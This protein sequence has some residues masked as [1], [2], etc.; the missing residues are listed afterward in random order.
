MRGRQDIPV[1]L[2]RMFSASGELLYI[3]QS[4]SPEKRLAQHRISADWITETALITVD[5]FSNRSSAMRAERSAIMAEAPLHNVA[6]NAKA[7]VAPKSDQ[8]MNLP[9]EITRMERELKEVGHSVSDLCRE[10]GI[11]A[12]TW[13]RWKNNSF[14]P[15]MRV[16]VDVEAAFARLTTSKQQV[17][18]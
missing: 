12:S 9:E 16:W 2:Y 13:G 15:R 6:N 11:N 10:A 8:Q 4:E 18:Q 17:S 14:H 1:A 3:G 7:E 5:W